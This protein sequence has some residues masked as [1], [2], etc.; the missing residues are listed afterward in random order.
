MAT[1]TITWIGIALLVAQSGIFSGLNLALFGV[2]ALRLR[3]MAN[4]GNEQATAV[5]AMRKDSNFLLTTILWGNVGTN[6]L[7]TLLSDSVLAGVTAFLFS[8]FVITFGGEIIPQAYFSRNALRMASLMS[9]MLRLYQILLY[10]L[11]KPS[12]LILDMWLGKESVDYLPEAEIQETIRQ[13]VRSSESD[14]GHVEGTGAINFMTLDDVLVTQEGEPVDPESV[15]RLPHSEG[16]PIFP[17]FE[18]TPQDPF[19]QQVQASGKNWVLVA[20]EE[21][22]PVLALD[23]PGFLRAALFEPEPVDP[24]TYCHKPV[25][26]SDRRTNLAEVLGSLK[27]EPGDDVIDQDLI[28]LWSDEKRVITGA[29]LFGYLMRGIAR[30]PA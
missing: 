29:D 14:I 4:M 3:T 19:L 28:L 1:E 26:V 21:G 8:T 25:I 5:L 12:A 2:S 6:V 15:L 20:P 24:L 16:R 18:A 30:L 27:A 10:P 17:T 11:A 13:H 23:A 9:P 22:A 7:L